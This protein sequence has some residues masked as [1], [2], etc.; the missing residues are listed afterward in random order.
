MALEEQTQ[1]EN[2]PELLLPKGNS[3][4]HLW[5][6]FLKLIFVVAVTAVPIYSM[7]VFEGPGFWSWSF[8]AVAVFILVSVFVARLDAISRIA[9]ISVGA[10]SALGLVLLLIAGTIGGSF[11]LSESNVVLAVLLGFLSVAGFSAN[12]GA[13]GKSKTPGDT[14]DHVRLR[15]HRKL[16]PAHQHLLPAPTQNS[17]LGMAGPLLP[18]RDFRP[19]ANKRLVAHRNSYLAPLLPGSQATGTL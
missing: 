16:A 19:L 18:R 11:H 3:A 17:I 12:S 7:S 15:F 8:L 10:L 4:C 1:S 5:T 9:G 14:D 13:S 2:R 6:I